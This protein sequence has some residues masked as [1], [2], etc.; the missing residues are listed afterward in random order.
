MRSE[1]NKVRPTVNW[2]FCMEFMTMVRRSK[3]NNKPGNLDDLRKGILEIVEAEEMESFDTFFM[4][5]KSYAEEIPRILHISVSESL[6]T[7]KLVM[8]MMKHHCTE[9]IRMAE[10]K[11]D[12]KMR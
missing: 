5:G 11:K 12:S 6:Q 9:L 2:E 1:T 3:S 8:L 7:T 4:R 10:L